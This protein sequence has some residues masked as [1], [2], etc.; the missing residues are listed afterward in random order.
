[1]DQLRLSVTTATRDE[2]WA[3]AATIADAYFRGTPYTLTSR[4]ADIEEID[5][6]A[7]GSTASSHYRFT[8][9]FTAHAGG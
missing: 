3:Q 1:M 5:V 7:F 2:A 4:G 9:A 6:M 8:T